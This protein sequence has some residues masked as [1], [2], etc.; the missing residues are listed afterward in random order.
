MVVEDE[1]GERDRVVSKVNKAE[2]ERRGRNRMVWLWD[3][4][5]HW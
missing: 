2:E 3:L 4:D 5:L 1:D